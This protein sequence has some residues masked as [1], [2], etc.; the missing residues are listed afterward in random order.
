[1]AEYH[2]LSWNWKHAAVYLVFLIV[3]RTNATIDTLKNLRVAMWG[4]LLFDVP[5]AHLNRVPLRAYLE[6]FR[7][8]GNS[9]PP[10][11]VVRN[12]YSQCYWSGHVYRDL[13]A[14]QR[15]VGR[16][17]TLQGLLDPF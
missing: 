13:R 2:S 4:R 10:A 17:P 11:N 14:E 1:M 5:F 6:T 12:G 15:L 9:I 16:I 3:D 7:N 8:L